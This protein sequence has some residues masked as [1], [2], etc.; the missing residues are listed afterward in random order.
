MAAQDPYFS[1]APT[2]DGPANRI[3]TVVPSDSLDLA[4][5]TTGVFV[6]QGGDLAVQD[7]SSGETVVFRNLA[8]GTGL[9]IRVARV[10]ATGTTAGQIVGMA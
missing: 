10:L 2:A 3:F 6:G 4:F 5:V 9:P 8:D 1:N 7:R